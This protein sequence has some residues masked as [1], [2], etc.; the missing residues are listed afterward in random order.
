MPTQDEILLTLQT[1]RDTLTTISTDVS[2]ISDAVDANPPQDL[3]PV[4]NSIAQTDQTIKDLG[5]QVSNILAKF[6]VGNV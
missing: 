4:A 3:Q 2:K 6:P 1:Q 5:T